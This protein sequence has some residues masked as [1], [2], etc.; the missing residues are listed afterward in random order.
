MTATVR[1]GK[2]GPDEQP[3][4]HVPPPAVYARDANPDEI[5]RGPRGL[6]GRLGPGWRSRATYSLGHRVRQRK[7]DGEMVKRVERHTVVVVRL[8]HPCGARA[9]GT[10]IQGEGDRSPG[11]EDAYT[12][13]RC[14]EPNCPHTLAG[15]GE[16]PADTAHPV[17]AAVLAGLVAGIPVLAED[18]SSWTVA[19]G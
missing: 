14:A 6:L 3:E 19:D 2:G 15:A 12:W 8:A 4:L 18:G 17:G 5:P 9:V 11:F 16:H 7:V 1:W 10:W 13:V